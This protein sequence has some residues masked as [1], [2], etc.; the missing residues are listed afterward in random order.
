MTDTLKK[1]TSESSL[2][3]IILISL[4]LF[5]TTFEKEIGTE[6]VTIYLSMTVLNI[7]IYILKKDGTITTQI[8]QKEGNSA[9]SLL[10][11]GGAIIGF[12]ALY[13]V[14]NTLFGRVAETSQTAFQSFFSALVKFSGVDFGQLT[15]VKYYLFGFL[16]PV[17]ETLT[18]I[19]IFVFIAWLFNVSVTNIKDPRVHAIIAIVSSAFM[20]FHLKVRGINNNIDLAMTFLFGYLSLLI[21]AK[22]MEIESAN[23]FHVGTNLLALIYGR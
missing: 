9:E 21:A 7:V 8:R 18:I 20:Y 10:W 17:T 1:I 3:I 6:I 11:A 2:I 5:K 23:E 12:T 22:T 13:S 19:G 16:I 15:P 4:L 14:V